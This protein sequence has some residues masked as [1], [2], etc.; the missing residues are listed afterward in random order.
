M[1]KLFLV[2]LLGISVISCCLLIFLKFEKSIILTENSKKEEETSKKSE[3]IDEP[4]QESNLLEDED[5]QITE[6]SEKNSSNSVEKQPESTIDNKTEAQVS[7]SND[8][9]QNAPVQSEENNSNIVKDDQETQTAD[10]VPSTDQEIEDFVNKT[11]TGFIYDFS[12]ISACQSEGNKWM[13]KGWRYDCIYMP[14]PN[15]DIIASMLIVSTGEYYC[16][17]Q[18]TANLEIDWRV[19]KNKPKISAISFLR[20]NGYE[21]SNLVDIYE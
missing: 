7:S 3:V 19:Y 11:I 12:S 18:F 1:K 13:E 4:V 15:S 17:N 21:C 20:D 8:V 6:N 2:L 5:V 9:P 16:D 10:E 14:I